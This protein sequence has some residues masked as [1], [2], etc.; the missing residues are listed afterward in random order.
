VLIFIGFISSTYS[1]TISTEAPSVSA[2]AVTVP[3]G[4]LQGELSGGIGVDNNGPETIVRSNE[5]PFLLLRYGISNRWELRMQHNTSFSK[6]NGV[7]NYQY[8]NFGIGAKYAILPNES[9][10]NLAVIGN[11]SPFAGIE[12]SIE[13]NLLIAFSHAFKERHS[14]GANVGYSL[15]RIDFGA[16]NPITRRASFLASMVY[17]WQFLD[18][19]TAFGEFYFNNSQSSIGDFD[20]DPEQAYGIDFGLQYLLTERIQLDWVSGFN[21]DYKYQFH[22]IGFNIYFDT[23]K[24]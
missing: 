10:T 5:S 17:S 12:N 21:L 24:K 23:N 13:G 20:F 7:G 9:N 11:F 3:K 15:N 14:V 18:N 16:P 22:S 6:T 19:W 2:S 1:Q 4:F 8:T